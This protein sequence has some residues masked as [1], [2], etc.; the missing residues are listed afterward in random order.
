MPFS[1]NGPSRRN[2]ET[3]I[4]V[5]GLDVDARGRLWILDAPDVYDRWPRIIIYDLKR[6][7]RLVFIIHFYFISNH[8][9]VFYVNSSSFVSLFIFYYITFNI[10]ICRIVYMPFI[11]LIN[12]SKL[13]FNKSKLDLQ[14]TYDRIY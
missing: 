11:Y 10:H 4:S 9:C 14:R 6:N 5:T 12:Y 13:K 7:D 1:K 3:L 8:T 2:Y